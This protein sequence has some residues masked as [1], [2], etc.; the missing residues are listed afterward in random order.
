MTD[1]IPLFSTA[2]S[3]KQGGIFSVEKAGYLGKLQRKRG[4]VSLCDLAKQEGLKRLHMVDD[5]FVNFFSAYRNLKEVGCD[6]TFGL[7][8]NVCED[9]ADKS[10]ASLKT[11]S[12]VVVFMAS[13]AGYLP[14]CAIYSKAATEGF[15][16]APR[17]D[18]K[19]LSAL[20]SDQ[21]MLTLPFYSSFL[22]RNTLTFSSIVPTLPAAPT[23][24]REVDQQLPFD[25]LLDEAVDRYAA[26]TSAP[27][28]RV[29]TCYYRNREDAKAFQVWRCILGR[30]T[31]DKPNMDHM[32]SREFCWQAYKELTQ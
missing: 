7:K 26:A 31:F 3:L 9:M 20:W 17:I 16:Y 1:T 13:G 8:L 28:Q 24:L 25:S 12:R 10:D 19:T 30:K 15:Y 5:R 11:E 14:L 27:I 18:W 2:A 23:L 21:L 29:K 22:A 32:H 4:P 6:L